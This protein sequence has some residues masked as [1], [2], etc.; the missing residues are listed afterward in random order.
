MWVGLDTDATAGRNGN[1]KGETDD[2]AVVTHVR[3]G[4]VARDALEA[5]RQAGIW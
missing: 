3:A 2:V 1:I 4:I 5:N